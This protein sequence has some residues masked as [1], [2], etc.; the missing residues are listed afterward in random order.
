MKQTDEI[1]GKSITTVKRHKIGNIL[2]GIL[3]VCFLC[4]LLPDKNAGAAGATV[5]ITT[6]NTTVVKGDTV[7]VVITVSSEEAMDGFD[8]YFTYDSRVL[9]FITGGNITSGNDDAFRI[10]DTKR[11]AGTTKITYSVKF[12]AR[13][14]GSC[15]ISLRKPYHV[16]AADEES[17]KMSISYNSLNILIRKKAIATPK[18]K[19]TI[20]PE[21]SGA[22]EKETKPEESIMPSGETASAAPQTTEVASESK[23]EEPALPTPNPKDV[24][25]SSKLRKLLV[26]DAV[27]AP[28]FSPKIK[29]YSA[30]VATDEKQLAISYET[31]D[32]QAKVVIKGNKDLKPGRNV[33]RVVVTGTTGEKTTYRLAITIQRTSTASQAGAVTLAVKKGKLYLQGSSTVE[34]LE[35]EDEGTIP[36]G[37]AEEKTTIDGRK[38]TTY[39]LENNP[40]AGFVLF[41]GKAEEK[42]FFLYDIEE[43]HLYPYEKVKAWYRSMNGEPAEGSDAD[44]R[45][46]QSLKYMVGILASFCGLML[47]IVIALSIRSRRR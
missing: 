25:G 10:N 15:T 7:Y 3:F 28:D 9:Q 11:E 8:A 12:R 20:A 32:S 6:K 33:I 39:A 22:P 31:K 19:E 14:A 27:F 1:S 16:Y 42:G 44:A 43:G 47:L 35:V 23:P 37:F 36:S 26:E 5:S 46:I 2:L 40:D 45:T 41:Y 24:P 30:I 34:V 17:S 18:P 4:I 21:E 13:K 38:I 29:K